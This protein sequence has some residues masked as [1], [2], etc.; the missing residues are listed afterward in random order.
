MQITNHDAVTFVNESSSILI[1]VLQGV[2]GWQ[3]ELAA[4]DLVVVTHRHRLPTWAGRPGTRVQRRDS[5]TRA[6]S[7]KGRMPPQSHVPMKIC[8]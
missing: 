5:Y 3:Q 2:V 8:S 4:V 1:Q 6:K 7:R